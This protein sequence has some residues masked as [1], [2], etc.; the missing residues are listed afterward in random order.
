[1]VLVSFP[2]LSHAPPRRLR[3]APHALNTPP[4]S[5]HPVVPCRAQSHS[6]RAPSMSSRPTTALRA[7]S[8]ALCVPHRAFSVARC[9]LPAPPH[10]LRLVSRPEVLFAS[11]TAP[12]SRLVKPSHAPPHHLRA[13]ILIT[14]PSRSPSRHAPATRLPLRRHALQRH[15]SLSRGP[16]PPSQSP[17]RALATVPRTHRCRFA[18]LRRRFGPVA[19]DRRAHYPSR[20]AA[21]HV[22]L[23]RAPQQRRFADTVSVVSRPQRR[24]P[25]P[26]SP[27][28]RAPIP[29]LVPPSALTRRSG[30]ILHCRQVPTRRPCARVRV[31]PPHCRF[32]R[33]RRHFHPCLAL[34]GL[35]RPR[36]SPARR[37]RARIPPFRAHKLMPH[38]VSRPLN[39][40]LRLFAAVSPPAPPY[41]LHRHL[42]AAP[43]LQALAPPSQP[44]RCRRVPQRR[45]RGP[46]HTTIT[47]PLSPPRCRAIATRH[48]TRT[49]SAPTCAHAAVTCP[50]SAVSAPVP[51]SRAVATSPRALWRPATLVTRSWVSGAPPSAPRPNEVP[52]A[53]APSHPRRCR[54]PS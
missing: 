44:S 9:P 33:A 22:T 27:P 15:G 30:A 6:L 7:P 17:S 23:V 39:L 32:E 35:V 38:A 16:T 25:R 31:P 43:P 19:P 49:R 5:S 8:L 1:M 36:T 2:A 50:N 18:A 13:A 21:R 45:R 52:R 54:S 4:R 3:A 41:Q 48:R 20:D 40:C 34:I 42:R 47:R 26:H 12:S 37:F 10:S 46:L 51:P 28:P 53:V 14:P 11:H 24:D 29:T